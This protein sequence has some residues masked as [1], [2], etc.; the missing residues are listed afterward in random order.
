MF[1][2]YD[3]EGDMSLVPFLNRAH[4]FEDDENAAMS[5]LHYCDCGYLIFQFWSEY[6]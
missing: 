3:E 4:K 2:G 6:P 1:L 5:G